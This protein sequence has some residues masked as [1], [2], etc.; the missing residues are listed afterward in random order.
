VPRDR[1]SGVNFIE[2]FNLVVIG[3]FIAM[4]L[5]L[6][7]L[8]VLSY[9]VLRSDQFTSRYGRIHDM[10]ASDATPPVSVIIPAYN[11]A[12]GI[13]ES[14]RS[15]IL[16]K[17]AKKEIIVVND[18]SS[19]DTLDRLVEEFRMEPIDAPFRPLIE[20]QPI[21]NVYR[22]LLPVPVIVVDK[23]NGGKGDAI[24]AGINVSQYPYVMGT[25]A[26][27]VL[28]EE[29]LLRAARHFV[30]DRAKTIAVGGNIR[31]INGC[32][33]RRGK[34]TSV[35]LPRRSIEMSQVIE[36]IR[37]FLGARPAWSA[38]N[39]L[40]IVSGA[41]GV[42]K[43]SAVVEVGGYRRH[44]LGE[45][46][47]LTMRLHRHFRKHHRPYRIVYAPDAV[48]WTEV[49]TGKDI[50]RKQRIRWHRGLMQVMW[51]YK[52]MFLNPRYGM[53]GMVGWPSYVAFEFLAPIMEAV[54][55]VVIPTS[56]VVGALRYGVA[57]PLMIIALGIGAA[58]SLIGLMLD[59]H[60]GYY[61]GARDTWR[62]LR[63]SL[64]EQLGPR[65]RT[66]WWRVRAMFWNPRH[67]TWGDMKR[68]GVANLG[69]SS[70][71]PEQVGE[72]ASAEQP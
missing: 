19:D 10:I 1:G 51:Q 64:L 56:M 45:D 26:D 47:E 60:F 25:D 50:L 54:G 40:L 11:E 70:S 5:Q 69:S 39:S 38:L 33:V 6:V 28:D 37:S 72:F 36:Y 17:Y 62:L 65:Q 21:K 22:S 41:F 43:K 3:Y 2:L 27:I 57:V 46:M 16:L 71:S 7:F 61:E 32:G 59:E 20:T 66:V 13:V 68:T 9:R 58:N 67:K 24:N 49:P 30:E 34:V 8:A 42:F 52:W 12:A 55:W 4:E 14:V 18:G 63:Y 23:E 48:A 35:S 29:C 15:I 31:P 53:V 44:H